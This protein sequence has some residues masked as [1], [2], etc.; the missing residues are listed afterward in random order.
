MVMKFIFLVLFLAISMILESC[1]D[2][3]DYTCTCNITG[4]GTISAVFTQIT[5]QEIKKQ[6]DDFYKGYPIATSTCKSEVK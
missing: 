6:C 5:E 2:K 1:S 3:K 4:N